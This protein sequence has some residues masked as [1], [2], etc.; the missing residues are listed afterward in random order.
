[1]SAITKNKQATWF[2]IN[3]E[4]TKYAHGILLAFVIYVFSEAINQF[5]GIQLLGLKKSPISTVMIAIILGLILG[6]IYN[7]GDIFKPGINFSLK[8]ILR[9]GIICLGV[10]LSFADVVKYGSLS[11]PL[12][13][14][15]IIAALVI[16][17]ILIKYLN[18]SEKMAYLI[19]IGTAICG[20]TAIVATAPVIDAKKGEIT[21]AIANIT[22]FGILA[23]FLYPYFVHY[24]YLND[25]QSAGLFLGTAIHETAQVAGAGLIYDQQYSDPQVLEISTITKL[26]R[27]TFLIVMIPLIAFF[28]SRG[29]KDQKSYSITKIFPYF[30]LGLLG[31]GYS[32]VRDGI[33]EDSIFI[34]DQAWTSTISFIKSSASVFLSMAMASLGLATK[35]SELKNLGFKPMI[36]GLTAAITVGVVSIITL[37]IF[38]K[39]YFLYLLN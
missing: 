38:Q 29:Q 20:A 13:I 26:V 3:P 34:A 25:P 31:D 30:I 39:V 5:V 19:A 37:E 28:Y 7:I 18:I 33:F 36:V 27:N 17:R 16:I 9:A 22:I 35:F 15:C 8:Y 2:R 1:V 11:I 21:Y 4:Y 24:F 12:V 6:N 14:V 23:M 32:L 10:R